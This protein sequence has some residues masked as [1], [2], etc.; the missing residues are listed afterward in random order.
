MNGEHKTADGSSGPTLAQDERLLR[1]PAVLE[2][3][4]RGRTKTLN[5]VKAGTFPKPI[6][7]G[8][9]TLWLHSEIL[10]WIADRVRESRGTE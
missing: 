1:L 3:T 6:K 7:C 9:A 5:D 8:V 2:M 10:S 4:S